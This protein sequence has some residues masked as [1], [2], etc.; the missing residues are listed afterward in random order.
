MPILRSMPLLYTLRRP[1]LD[2]TAHQQQ[3]TTLEQAEAE[4]RGHAVV[5]DLGDYPAELFQIRVQ[6]LQEWLS[7]HYP[8]TSIYIASLVMILVA[9]MALIATGLGLHVA[10]GK[11]WVLGFIV[12]VI[13]IFISKMV[14]LSRIEK[15]HKDMNHQLLSFN[16]QDM[17]HYG[18]LYRL[19]PSN[20]SSAHHASSWI[21]RCAYRLNLGL[22]RWT[23]DL[24]T[25][26][27][28]DEY[29]FQEHP[30]TDPHATPEEIMAR[31]NELPTYRPKAENDPEHRELVLS[32][33]QPPKYQDVYLE[34]ETLPQHHQQHSEENTGP[35]NSSSS[36][37]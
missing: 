11:P 31:E 20:P 29:S 5:G 17:S 27:H 25:I 30:A 28:I 2:L 21:S 32:E 13:A 33:S 18:V 34:M 26:D 15:A 36:S 10:D 19:R 35:S 12:V 24:T 14:F 1:T 4:E 9:T 37:S 22:P 8:P 7:S 6:T 16:N 3:L 23:V